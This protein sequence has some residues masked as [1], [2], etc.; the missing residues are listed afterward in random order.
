MYCRV[1]HVRT[2]FVRSLRLYSLDPRFLVA[3]HETTAATLS[4]LFYELGAHLDV[5]HKLRSELF[6]LDTDRPT[7]AQ[8]S[9]LCYL[10]GVVREVI[11]LHPSI[12]TSLRIA[13]K[14]DWI[15]LGSPM[16]LGG[17]MVDHILSVR[18]QVLP[19]EVIT[20]DVRQC[21]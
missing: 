2:L 6:T 12:P 19:S 4:W 11:R 18:W 15:P 13:E 17:Q 8:L 10:D 20:N 5:Q 3:G 9:S 1:L 7:I 16:F 21:S 14:D